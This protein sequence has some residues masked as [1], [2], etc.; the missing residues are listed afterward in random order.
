M[1]SDRIEAG[2]PQ[3]S[4]RSAPRSLIP[5]LFLTVV[6]NYMD[7][8]NVAVAAPALREEFGLTPAQMGLIFSAFAWTYSALQIPGGLVADRVRAR[9]LYPILLVGW[10]V[11]TLAQAAA[12]GLASLVGARIVIGAFEAPSFPLNNRIVTEWV[13]PQNRASAIAFYTSGQFLG[14]ALL[15]PLLVAIQDWAGWRGLFI[16]TGLIGIA[17]ALVWYAVYRDP[18]QAALKRPSKEISRDNAQPGLSQAGL[19]ALLTNPNLVGIYL[20]QFCL[21]TLTIFFLTWFPTY[22]VD[23][24]GIEFAQSGWLAAIPFLAAFA[25]VLVSGNLSDWLIRRGFSAGLAR[26]GPVLTGMLLST[27]VFGANYTDDT[28]LALLF[29]S[30][31]FFGNGL[32]SIAW[33]FVSLLAPKGRVGIVGGIFNF[34]GALSAVVTPLAIGL[35]V[36]GEN[37]A[38]ALTYIGVFALL[39]SAS[40]LFLVRQI[41]PIDQEGQAA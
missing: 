23:Y 6:I 31:A 38:P 24:R 5:M 37:F 35:L 17:W 16:I 18:P 10:S 12:S 2:K 28:A 34:C 7:R 41:C 29:L 8:T 39:G 26:K 4:G 14:L 21:G 25:G 32:A 40:Y 13:P 15:A 1:R 11:A 19:S 22:L 36:D 20:G 33:V 3:D 27:A 9:L 30:I